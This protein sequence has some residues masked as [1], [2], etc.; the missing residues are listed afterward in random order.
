MDTYNFLDYAARNAMLDLSPYIERDNLD[1][2]ALYGAGR[3]VN[4]TYEDKVYAVPKDSDDPA[5][6]YN[7]DLFDAAGLEYP[8]PDVENAW[9]WDEFVEVAKQL[10]LDRSGNN[11]S[12]PN[13]NPEDIGQYGIDFQR[14]WGGWMTAIYMGGNDFANEDGTALTINEPD[15]VDALQKFQ[16]L[17]FVHHVAP[18]ASAL[19]SS[20]ADALFEAGQLAM[21]MNGHWKVL[22]YSQMSGLNWGMGVLP[23]IAEPITAQV[24]APIV[25]FAATPHPAEVVEFYKFLRRPSET[26]NLF[27]RGLWMPISGEYYTDPELTAQWLDAVPGVY[28]PE[29]RDVLIDYAYNYSQKPLPNVWLK[30]LAQIQNEAIQPAVDLIWSGEAT[31]QE[32]MDQAVAAA[33]PM[34]QGRWDR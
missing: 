3:M 12:N 19:Q 16:D 32:A 5:L 26:N 10:T 27:G 25:G 21:L 14:W 1:V 23:V 9:T 13:F 33:E 15:A 6:Y 11:A 28:P 29:S 22:D 8:A 24:L 17:I 20:S 34:M 18:T 30:N 2:A 7:K 31:A 4:V